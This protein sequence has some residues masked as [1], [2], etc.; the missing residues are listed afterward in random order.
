MLDTILDGLDVILT[1]LG[2]TLKELDA[3]LGKACDAYLIRLANR[4]YRFGWRVQGDEYEP[5]APYDRDEGM[6]VKGPRQWNQ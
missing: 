4:L 2:A 5:Y 3:W 6:T 1:E